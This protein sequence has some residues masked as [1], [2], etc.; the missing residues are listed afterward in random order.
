MFCSYTIYSV[1]DTSAV[2][3]ITVFTKFDAQIIQ[4]YA[5]LN[6]VEGRNERW[7]K[8]RANAQNFFKEVYLSKVLNATHLPRGFLKLEGMQVIEIYAVC[9]NETDPF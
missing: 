9:F 5:K 6:D 3:L 8:A 1:N 4:E 2:P 7:N